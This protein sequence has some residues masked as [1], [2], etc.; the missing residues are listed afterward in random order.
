MTANAPSSSR[1]RVRGLFWTAPRPIRSKQ[2]ST[3]S[4]ASA[5]VSSFPI[6]ASVR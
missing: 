6:S 3:A 4:S 5:G 2:A 1:I